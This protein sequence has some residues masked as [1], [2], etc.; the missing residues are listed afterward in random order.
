M[1]ITAWAIFVCKNGGVTGQQMPAA[2]SSA[3]EGRGLG[4]TALP[5]G[6][7]TS[8]EMSSGRFKVG[9]QSFVSAAGT[10]SGAVFTCNT[11]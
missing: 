1:L 5:Q 2:G 9:E 3:L 8:T 7:G 11:T 4:S 6:A 10:K